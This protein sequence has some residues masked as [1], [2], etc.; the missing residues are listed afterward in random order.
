MILGI[1]P[2]ASGALAFFDPDSGLLD[3]IDTPVVEVMRGN[4]AKREIS[5][6]MLA[7]LIKARMPDQ[8]ILERV[9]A[10]PEAM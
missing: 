2:G 5:P 4:K 8:V 3:I 10:M 9:G 7:A 1:D 6:P